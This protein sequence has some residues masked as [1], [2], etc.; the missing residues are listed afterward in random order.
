M[1]RFTKLVFRVFVFLLPT[2]LAYHFWPDW[3]LVFGIRVDYLAPTVY[4]TDILALIL[5]SLYFIQ[6]KKAKERKVNYKAWALILTFVILNTFFAK[7][8]LI[9]LFKWMKVLELYL[10]FTFVK[11][12]KPLDFYQ[13]FIKPL[14]LSSLIFSVI[15]V[16]QFLRGATLGG[17]FYLLG[18]RSFNLFTP[19]IALVKFY[20]KD[21]L[22]AY[23]TFSHPNSLAGFLS[24]VTIFIVVYI[25]KL[26][27]NKFPLLGFGV[28][29]L[30]LGLS[31]SL[32]AL[33]ALLTS[34][35]FYSYFKKKPKAA[36][37]LVGVASL[38]LLFFQAPNL[39]RELPLNVRERADLA[40]VSR[41]ISLQNPF[42]GIGLNNFT[43]AKISWSLQPVHNIYLLV[44]A[45]TG[46]AGVATLF[47]VFYKG[48]KKSSPLKDP[49]VFISLLFILFV[50][51]ID[52]YFL[53]LQQNLLL[54][55][56][57]LGY[58]Q[59]RQP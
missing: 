51:L 46:I 12:F 9:A 55:S 35:A 13:D 41:Q 5:I 3:A 57:I 24:I 50:G 53:T 2:Q 16:L 19:G 28:I 14:I 33:V 52:H 1:Q 18:E 47:Y 27:K 4:L 34:F 29:F 11:N 26:F 58:S 44:F 36:L 43:A 23:S 31:F 49:S 40:G 20:G 30:G 56:L 38:A 15:G 59:K 48:L 7:V 32:G 45:E 39:S 10:I 21:Y 6:K 42:T 17:V 54:F 37:L 22:R 25:K 8:P